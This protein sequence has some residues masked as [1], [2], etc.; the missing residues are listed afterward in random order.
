MDANTLRELVSYDEKTGILKWR[1]DHKRLSWIKAGDEVGKSSL[2][3]GYKCTAIKGK[4]YYQHR[5]VWLYVHGEWPEQSI[6]HINGDKTDNRIKNLRLATRSENQHNRKKT[7]K[8]TMGAYRHYSGRW[9]STIMI[10]NKKHYLGMFKNEEE[11]GK[12]YAEA[13]SKLHPF[14]PNVPTR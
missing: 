3:M 2:K 11:A 5:L 6:D 7:K 1:N 9:Y 10:E 13:K 8:G 12:A 14:N 4:Q